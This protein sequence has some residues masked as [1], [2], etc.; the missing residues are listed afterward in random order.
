[1]SPPAPPPDVPRALREVDALMKPVAD[2][3]RLLPALTAENAV[4]ERAR[5]VDALERREAP[6]PAWTLRPARVEPAVWRMLERARARVEGEP[7]A[8]LYL[9]RLDELELELAMIEA[10]GDA[11][12][13]RPLAARRFGTGR[14][15]VEAPGGRAPAAR[16]ARAL[17]DALPHREEPHTVPAAAAAGRPSLAGLMLAVAREA[18]LSIE[19]KV[20][21][22][23]SAGAATGD[24]TVFLADRW[25]GAREAQRFAVHEVLGHAVAAANARAQPLRLFEIGTAGA[26]SAQEGLCLCLEERAG[27]LDPYRLR[28][29]AARVLAADR[30]H[31]GAPFGDTARWLRR[32]HELSAADAIGVAERAYRGGG[33]ARDVG[34]LV[35]WL[36]VRGALERGETNVDDLRAGRVDVETA[37]ALP[38]LIEAGLARPPRHRPSLSSSRAA[39]DAGTSFETSPPSLAASFTMLEET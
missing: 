35:G 9:A 34:Y 6:V 20:E 18:G 22:R 39:T 33:V 3:A 17:L 24:R 23:L 11:R 2:T 37:R 32:E 21:P 28:I 38:R 4:E 8:A 13:V 27:L 26:F 12:R 31:H 19:V 7:I 36:R 5:L 25:F 14:T 30:M 29:V 1:M 10:L 15:E 16:F